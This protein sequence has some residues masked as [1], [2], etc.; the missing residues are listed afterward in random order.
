M[1]QVKD[2]VVE[3]VESIL[4]KAQSIHG[5]AFSAIVIADTADRLERWVTAFDDLDFDGLG[6]RVCYH[7]ASSL[8]Q[9]KLRGRSRLFAVVDSQHLPDE[10]K[11]AILNSLSSAALFAECSAESLVLS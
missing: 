9:T 8:D 10:Y 2:K 5:I 11:S 1:D 7:L 6:L 3:I 4:P